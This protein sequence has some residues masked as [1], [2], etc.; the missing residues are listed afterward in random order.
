[1]KY[2]IKDTTLGKDALFFNNLTEVV[3]HLEGT[4]Q[5]KFRQTRKQYMQN[6]IDLGHGYDDSDGKNFTEA[7]SKVVEIGLQKPHGLVRCNVHEATNH[8]RYRTESGD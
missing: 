2:Y 4:V 7:L 6:L 8:S 1:M 5:R 3:K